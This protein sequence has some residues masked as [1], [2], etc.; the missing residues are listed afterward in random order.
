MSAKNKKFLL[1]L[2]GI[3]IFQEVFF[4]LVFPL[5]EL[6]NFDRASYIAGAENGKVFA[7]Y[8]DNKWYWQSALDTNHRFIHQLNQYGFR[9]SEWKVEK[10]TSKKRILFIGDSFL[11]GIMAAQNETITAGFNDAD[12]LNQYETMN[13]GIMGVGISSY[14]KLINHANSTFKPDAICI[15][16]YSNDLSSKNPI[17]SNHHFIPKYYSFLKPRLIELLSQFK[18]GENINSAFGAK[19]KS[20]LPTMK[21]FNFPWKNR[22]DILIKNTTV[23]VTTSISEGKTNPFKVNQILRERKGLLARPKLDEL[24]NAL[25]ELKASGV[26]V[27]VGYI[28]ARHQVTNYY[29][30]FDKQF[31]TQCPQQLDLTTS[32]F[33][34]HQGLLAYTCQK[35]ELPIID[36]TQ[37]LRAEEAIGNHLYW[38]YDDHMKGKGYLMLGELL[39]SKIAEEIEIN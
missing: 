4:R 30:Q 10:P 35:N 23:E 12:K 38:N 36:F 18:N 22:E 29:Y 2:V 20:F 25:A 33:N 9:D 39:Y 14:L 37:R 13:L 1:Y 3:L 21:D 26:K 7:P 16:L 19:E 5:P 6:S 15:L 24:F 17:V 11:E 34:Q 8:R 27:V 28:P 32:E 31:C